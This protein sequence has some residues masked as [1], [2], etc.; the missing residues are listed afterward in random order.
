MRLLELIK[1]N[2]QDEEKSLI[3]LLD[4]TKTNEEIVDEMIKSGLLRLGNGSNDDKEVRDN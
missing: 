4:I 3:D 2:L 1:S